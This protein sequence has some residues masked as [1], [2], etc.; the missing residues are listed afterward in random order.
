MKEKYNEFLN[1]R[2][3]IMIGEVVENE[4][5]VKKLLQEKLIKEYGSAIRRLVEEEKPIDEKGMEVVDLC[6]RR[7][8][9]L[10][11][12]ASETEKNKELIIQQVIEMIMEEKEREESFS[13]ALEMQKRKGTVFEGFENDPDF[14]GL[15]DFLKDKF[16]GDLLSKALVSRVTYF[17]DTVCISK[18]GDSYYL[19][20]KEYLKWKKEDESIASYRVSFSNMSFCNRN[21]TISLTPIE[22][23]SFIDED[24]QDL[25]LHKL[26]IVSR[27]FA[28][29][30]YINL[31]TD[32]L[33]EQWC[34]L[35]ANSP[36]ED[37]VKAMT[38]NKEYLKERSPRVYDF[39]KNNIY[40]ENN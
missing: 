25:P 9:D 17:P 4:K 23:Y 31:L 14:E 26:E 21:F 6:S 2:S 20:I 37:F 7:G 34:S 15:H 12:G 11:I 32:E 16:P 28:R 10:N 24:V 22:L 33:K 27:E 29:N 40:H 39:L 19:P 35:K 38:S 13:V 36:E 8:I 5:E 1:T 30:I 18:E 3:G